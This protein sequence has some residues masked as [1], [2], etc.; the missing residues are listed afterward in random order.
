VCY[1]K[2]S[3]LNRALQVDH[4]KSST[5]CYDVVLVSDISERVV[6]LS[7][8]QT[9]NGVDYNLQGIRQVC[10]RVLH[11]P[12]WASRPSR[13]SERFK[14]SSLNM[15]SSPLEFREAFRILP[16]EIETLNSRRM[17]RRNIEHGNVL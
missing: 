16:E 7:R 2:P 11:L 6:E 12:I 17:H 3:F 13:I 8:S 1:S 9:V 15:N 10:R 5:L 4:E 14:V